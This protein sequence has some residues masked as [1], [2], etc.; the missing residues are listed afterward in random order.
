MPPQLYLPPSPPLYHINF[1]FPICDFSFNVVMLQNEKIL[2]S[3]PHS[4]TKKLQIFETKKI[5]YLSNK[6]SN[7]LLK[8]KNLA[9][10]TSIVPSIFKVPNFSIA[11]SSPMYSNLFQ[12]IPR[13]LS[14]HYTF[15]FSAKSDPSRG[16][17][18]HQQPML[19]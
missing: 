19:P 9:L 4:S 10:D 16:H 3:C 1:L 7:V 13:L 5:S 15:L 17:H 6:S 14:P 8:P 12:V 18:S 2:C 11:A